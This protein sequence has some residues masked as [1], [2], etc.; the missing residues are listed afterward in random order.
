[1]IRTR[2]LAAALLILASSTAR[3]VSRQ[4]DHTPQAL[5]AL[6]Q[7]SRHGDAERAVAELSTWD[8]A[9]VEAAWRKPTSSDEPKDLAAAAMLH[10]EAGFRTDTFGDIK[11]DAP[12]FE[13]L[14]G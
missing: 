5:A 6:I 9:D 4:S 10:T 12:K 2:H 8:A 7:Q 1:M 11:K 3:V 14:S 13:L